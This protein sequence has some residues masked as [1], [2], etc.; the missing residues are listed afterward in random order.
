ML[1]T[2]RA[3]IEIGVES[4]P[5]FAEKKRYHNEEAALL[6]TKIYEQGPG[7]FIEFEN[8]LI[9]ERICDLLTQLI[10]WCSYVVLI[11]NQM[12]AFEDRLWRK[13][14]E[15]NTSNLLIL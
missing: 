1:V 4:N 14:S 2:E 12:C 9:R 13:I 7:L 10:K 6:F 15:R 5:M 11:S 8:P 3:E